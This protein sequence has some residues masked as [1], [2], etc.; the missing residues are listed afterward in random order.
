MTETDEVLGGG[1]KTVLLVALDRGHAEPGVELWVRT[2]GARADGTLWIGEDVDDWRQ[3]HGQTERMK[4]A[5]GG[6]RVVVDTRCRADLAVGGL[7]REGVDAVAKA[8]HQPALL[9]GA[10]EERVGRDA[11]EVAQQHLQLAGRSVVAGEK[12]HPAEVIA[13]DPGEEAGRRR[14]AG[15]ADDE[16]LADFLAQGARRLW[17]SGKRERRDAEQTA[18]GKGTG[19]LEKCAAGNGHSVGSYW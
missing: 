15:E 17:R 19:S 7:R 18:G 14:R 13:L 12:D 4:V 16:E 11:L 9:I 3:V 1:R 5:G 8:D 10:D 2:V 6:C